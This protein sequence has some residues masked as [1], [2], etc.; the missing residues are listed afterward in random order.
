M[1]ILDSRLPPQ[2]LE[3]EQ[4][5]LGAILID[6]QAF[7][8]VVDIVMPDDFYRPA[9]G[10][11]YAGMRELADK[12]KP[13]DVVTLTAILKEQGTFEEIGGA[14]YLAEILERVPTAMNVEYHAR[15]ISDQA[16]KRRLVSVCGEISTRGFEPGETTEEL[17]DYA[18][19]SIF[20]L[21]SSRK[22][23]NLSPVHDIVKSAFHELEKRFENQNE[24]TGV[25]TGY[26][27]L[28]RMTQGFQRS[29]LIIVACRPS[30]GKTS[31]SLGVARHAAVHA[32]APVVFF[33][34]EMSK[35]QIVTRLLSAEAKVDQ[36]RLRSGRLTEQDWKKLTSAAGFL[37]DAPIYI[38]DTASLTALEMRGKAR[39]LKAELG[40]VGIVI[41]DY[42]QIMGTPGGRMESRERAI[43][44]ISRS[45]KALAKEL[46]A[47][48]VALSQLNRNIEVRQDK[49]PLMADLRESGAIEQDAD[50]IIFIHREDVENLQP[51]NASM[52]EFI[53]GKHRNG[54]RGSVKV[55][56]LGQYAT[57]ENLATG[58]SAGSNPM[59]G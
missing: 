48:V 21:S 10:K 36:S 7:Y 55:A 32:K 33:S 49:R 16:V 26:I 25:P 14:S 19:K 47:P 6:N 40:E 17:L 58:P 2:N 27:D 5:V 42:L 38:D 44:D 9:N 29:D 1:G 41:V 20:G 30:M 34:L 53:V 3:A 11:I 59:M 51:G 12:S 39:R 46:N 56:W 4:S 24:V 43:S 35:E 22:T 28:D 52:A 8:R 18:E 37:S 57:F 13:I 45:L 31:F 50:L 15:L 54:P 23:Q